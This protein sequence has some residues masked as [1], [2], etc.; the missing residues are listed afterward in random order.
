[1]ASQ[2][3]KL[4]PN[5]SGFF[6]V[7]IILDSSDI[8]DD[9]RA[10]RLVE[11]L[12]LNIPVPVLY[13]AETEDAKYEIIDGQQ[14]VRSIVRYVSNEFGLTSL[15]VLSDYRGMRFHE[16]PEREQRFLKMRMVRAVIISHESHPTMKFEIFERLNS[17][18]MSLNP[19]E[20]RNSIYRGPFNKMLR[21]L[22]TD[23]RFRKVIGTKHPRPRMLD[24]ELLLRFFA[25]ARE[26]DKYRPPLKRFLNSFMSSVRHS[27]ENAI[28]SFTDLFGRTIQRV[29]EALGMAA[30]RLVD[31]RGNAQEKTINRSLFDA[32][33]LIFSWMNDEQVPIETNRLLVDLA[34][35]YQQ[36]AFSDLIRRSTGDRSRTRMR[37]RQL[38]QAITGAGVALTVPFDLAD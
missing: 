36:P 14:R 2:P 15:N 4:Q 16:L 10:S 20:L 21:H 33:M 3:E 38:V 12:L 9:G 27:D 34:Q 32:Q 24:E 6:L 11:S 25:L 13:F 30:F 22:V 28:A 23:Q 8:W 29:S 17:G 1:M 5:Q 18:S 31:A 19:Q 37:V 35:I 7:S 26:Y